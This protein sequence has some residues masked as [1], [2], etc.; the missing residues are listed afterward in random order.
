MIKKGLSI[1][2]LLPLFA[3]AS[4]WIRIGEST[5]G[6]KFFVDIQSISRSG[7]TVT[8]WVRTNYASRDQDGDLSSK[9]NQTMNCATRE[10]KSIY[11]MFYD[12]FDNQGI[13]SSSFAAR[14][15]EWRPIAPDTVSDSIYRFLCK[16]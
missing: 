1:V 14:N 11:L 15:K 13:N 5:S 9:I 8:Y 2:L 3:M 12:D 6:D 10:L 4:N 16:K 7:N